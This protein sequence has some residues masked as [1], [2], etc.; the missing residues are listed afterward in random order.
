ML[1]SAFRDRP[2]AVVYF[3]RGRPVVV[4]YFRGGGA[5]L[6]F[7]VFPVPTCLLLFGA[8]LLFIARQC[9]LAGHAVV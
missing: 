2:V 4:Y 7:I 9:R 3:F 8:A 6:L 1:F 5:L